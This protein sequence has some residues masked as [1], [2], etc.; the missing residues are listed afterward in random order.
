MRPSREFFLKGALMRRFSLAI[1]LVF[2]LAAAVFSWRSVASLLAAETA[3]VAGPF[4]ACE[5][6]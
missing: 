5:L 3:T 1:L 2:T 6:Q 4:S